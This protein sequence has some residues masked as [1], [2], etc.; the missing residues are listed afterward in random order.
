MTFVC[1]AHC[2]KRLEIREKVDFELLYP[3][4]LGFSTNILFLQRG[5]P[6]TRFFLGP[7]NRVK[8]GVPV[9][10]L[11]QP[12]LFSFCRNNSQL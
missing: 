3:P 2:S 8:G 4:F 9:I 12:N 1:S 6:L 5:F 7:K 11:I 10:D